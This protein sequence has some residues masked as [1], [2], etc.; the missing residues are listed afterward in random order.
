MSRLRIKWTKS[1]IG[2]S[3]GQKQTRKALGLR[4]LGQIMEHEDSPSIRGMVG[5]VRHL[6]EVEVINDKTE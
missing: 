1:D 5:K 4:R 2:Y 3:R 6:V